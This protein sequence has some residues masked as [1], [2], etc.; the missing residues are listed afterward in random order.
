[1]PYEH[2]S[3]QRRGF[4]SW[5]SLKTPFDSNQYWART[6]SE[7]KILRTPG[8]Y[9]CSSFGFNQPI[10]NEAGSV[11]SNKR[12]VG[13]TGMMLMDAPQGP[14]CVMDGAK[15]DQ[16][17]KYAGYTFGAVKVN[18]DPAVRVSG[19]RSAA[20]SGNFGLNYSAMINKDRCQCGPKK[21]QKTDEVLNPTRYSN[22]AKKYLPICSGVNESEVARLSCL[23]VA[24]AGSQ[25]VL[26]SVVAKANASQMQQC[27][28]VKYGVESVKTQFGYISKIKCQ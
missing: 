17:C 21:Y 10:Y 2:S 18:S 5:G 24:T 20:K 19:A 25:D 6:P 1:M 11:I 8:C 15:C 9:N 14:R 16:T 4:R 3:Y 13:H 23:A 22:T 7:K 28:T 27:V 26:G 12:I